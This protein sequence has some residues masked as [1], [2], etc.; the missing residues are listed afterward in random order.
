ML[1]IDSFIFFCIRIWIQ[2]F[3]LPTVKISFYVLEWLISISKRI[4][5]YILPKQTF[6]C[7]VFDHIESL[8]NSSVDAYRGALRNI[9]G[10]ILSDR[11]KL[12]VS[13]IKELKTILFLFVLTIW[14]LTSLIT[15]LY[16]NS[17]YYSPTKMFDF[18]FYFDYTYHGLPLTEIVRYTGTNEIMRYESLE[19]ASVI[20]HA[21]ID[22]KKL[23]IKLGIGESYDVSIKLELPESYAN[24][25][26][27]MFML[28][29]TMYAE[30]STIIATS[31]R[32]LLLK[33]TSNLVT[34]IQTIV[35][36]PLYF[37]S[38]F[39]EKQEIHSLMI[40]NYQENYKLQSEYIYVS[41]SNPKIEVY[42]SSMHFALK[43]QGLDKLII[44]WPWTAWVVMIMLFLVSFFFLCIL[45]L[46]AILFIIIDIIHTRLPEVADMFPSNDPNMYSLPVF[47]RSNGFNQ[48]QEVYEDI[49]H[50]D[51]VDNVTQPEIPAT[52]GLEQN[53]NPFETDNAVLRHR[54]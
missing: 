1:Y 44:N 50:S 18:P 10:W 6:L 8:Y 35:F 17:Y 9:S 54:N 51:E 11:P 48:M 40:E 14:F 24:R 47:P 25:D 36:F 31:G 20:P 15:V 27:G 32:P 46:Q 30:N 13:T 41:V 38:I 28:N 21:F 19:P 34:Y 43:P 3:I 53:A 49:D 23:D 37:L 7:R 42:E 12:I 16:G 33:F 39:Q 26:A 2:F 4:T 29:L 22:L 52:D 45:T 5:F